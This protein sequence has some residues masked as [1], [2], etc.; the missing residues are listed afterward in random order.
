MRVKSKLLSTAIIRHSFGKS[1]HGFV[2]TLH[3]A[4]RA[5]IPCL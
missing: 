1:F 3:L 2:P 5:E 4:P